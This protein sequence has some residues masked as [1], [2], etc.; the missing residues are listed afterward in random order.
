MA[1][2]SPS[3]TSGGLDRLRFRLAVSSG[4]LES[5]SRRAGSWPSATSTR[6]L[7]R[8]RRAWSPA[9]GLQRCRATF[10]DGTL[11]FV[12]ICTRPDSHR[13][14]VELAAAHGVAR[15]LPEAGRPVAAR[16]AGDDRGCDRAG[17]RLMIHEN[18]RFRPW[19]RAIRA[20]IDAGTIGRPIRLRIAHRDTRAL[21]PD[22]FADQPYF[23]D[24]APA[25][26]P[27]DGLPPGRH[28]PLPHRRGPD[29]LRHAGPLRRRASRRR[30][31]HALRLL[32]GGCPGPARHELVRPADVARPEWA[33]NET[34]A[35]G[36]G[37]T[38]RLRPTA[39]SNGSAPPGRRSANP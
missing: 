13:E 10:R 36:T 26:P 2:E 33:L 32:R 14:L 4:G 37:G 6:A 20:E 19:Y 3:A 29:G 8:R 39:R 9:P 11:D 27:G 38:L 1:N 25:D 7:E 15:P 28:R 5:T 35:E 16:A 12:E 18:W 24:D 17:I 21:R 30:R 31:G 34:V 23:A 22:G